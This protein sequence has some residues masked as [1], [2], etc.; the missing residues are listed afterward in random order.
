[1]TVG[2]VLNA[3]PSGRTDNESDEETRAPPSE[4]PDVAA[5]GAE[6]EALR[7]DL[8]AKT[9]SRAD[10]E[11][12]LKQY[13]RARQRRGKARGWGPYLVLLYGTVMTLGAFTSLS[14]GWAILAMI[15]V[16]LSTLG[17]Y[18]LM[19][20]VG[21][22]ASALGAPGRLVDRVRSWRGP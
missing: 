2:A 7:E 14:G 10:L 19:V 11:A 15:V 18:A 8:D 21:V 1:M 5:L 6:V 17:L 16:W 12:E 22:G 13:V 3:V 20:V 9:V 4:A